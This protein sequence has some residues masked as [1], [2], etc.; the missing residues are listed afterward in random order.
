[1]GVILTTYPFATPIAPAEKQ[2]IPQKID[3]W[4][5]EISFENGPPFWGHVN[6]RGKIFY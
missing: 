5:D 3:L 2:H 1:M 4:K 6:F